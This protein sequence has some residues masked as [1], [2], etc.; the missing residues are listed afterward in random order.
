VTIKL[1]SSDTKLASVPASV[2]I[3]AGATSATFPIKVTGQS[4]ATDVAIGAVYQNRGPAALLGVTEVKG[5]TLP[6]DGTGN[7]RLDPRPVND[8]NL[9]ALG[10]Y[11]GGTAQLESGQMPPGISLISNLRPGEFDF[12]GSP[13]H[14]GTYTFVLKFT[15]Q[16]QTPYAI[17]YV[18][19]ITP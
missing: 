6:A 18:W 12:H 17:A 16:V 11:S 7:Q 8:P 2:V 3:P 15:G 14:A 9:D 4:G 13:Q 5:G 10:Y 1:S 19:V